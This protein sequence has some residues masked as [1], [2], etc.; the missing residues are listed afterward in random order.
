MPPK[1]ISIYKTVVSMFGAKAA[2]VNRAIE[3]EMNPTEMAASGMP[4][5]WGIALRHAGG[6]RQFRDRGGPSPRA[7]YALN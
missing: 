6:D 3:V 7:V 4:P 2:R 1:N 5:G